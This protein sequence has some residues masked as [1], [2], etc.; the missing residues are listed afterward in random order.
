MQHNSELRKKI[1]TSKA[2]SITKLNWRTFKI[3]ASALGITQA[4]HGKWYEDEVR[5]IEEAWERI[6]RAPFKFQAD[7]KSLNKRDVKASAV[8]LI[9]FQPGLVFILTEGKVSDVFWAGDPYKE[10]A[11]AA[12]T[13]EKFLV[14]PCDKDKGAELTKFY[15]FKFQ[16]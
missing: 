8:P 9:L 10:L 2:L 16:L 5:G 14:L 11:Y 6:N 12:P 13:P 7:D 3:R 1:S 15:R 4:S